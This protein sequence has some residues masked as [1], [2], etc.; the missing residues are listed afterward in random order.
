MTLNS[1]R[2]SDVIKIDASSWAVTFLLFP[3]PASLAEA[4]Q[5]Q[6][7]SHGRQG[8]PASW[9]WGGCSFSG[10]FDYAIRNKFAVL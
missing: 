9:F 6:A 1:T 5:R 2:C 3:L 7:R 4:E 10:F 8:D